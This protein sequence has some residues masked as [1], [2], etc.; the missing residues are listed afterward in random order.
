[1][2][3]SIKMALMLCLTL[4]LTSA[5]FSQ[6]Q[7]GSIT[8]LVTDNEGNTLPG[9]TL[10]VSSP[11]LMGTR[12]YVSSENGAFRFPA[13]PPGTYKLTAEMQAF[14]TV[15]RDDIV[16]R[17][18][19]VV[20]LDIIMQLT[21]IQEEVAVTAVA[22]VV[23]VQQ[24]KIAIS[25][26][27][28]QLRNLPVARDMLDVINSAP[29]ANYSEGG[30]WGGADRMTS[31]HGSSVR[32]NTYAFDG[33][34]MND[35]VNMNPVTNINFDVIEEVEMILGGQ[36]A[37]VG[38]T[39]GAYV[40]IVTRSG[41]N[42][43]TGGV[44]FYNINENYFQQ[45]WTNEQFQ[46]M[47]VAK[48][49]VDKNF[50]DLSFSLG[51]P[52]LRDKLWFFAN[53]RYLKNV[54][55]GTYLPWD[56]TYAIPGGW[57]HDP[58]PEW[59]HREMM[60]FGKLTTQ[61]TP[62]I[63]LM[64]MFNYTSTYRP[65]DA[66]PSSRTFFVATRKWDEN[67]SAATGTLTYILNQNT[68][69]DVKGSYVH[70]YFKQPFQD[71]TYDKGNVAIWNYGTNFS[72]GSY[73]S[74]EE[75]WTKN[76]YQITAGITR[77][78]ENWL[79]G[80]HEIKGGLEFTSDKNDWNWWRKDPMYW[81][82]YRGSPYYYG[83]TVASDVKTYGLPP[84]SVGIGYSLIGA[85]IVGPNEGDNPVADLG[86]HIS[87]FL[88]D[89]MTIA[90]RL[91]INA[92]IRYD[93][94][95]LDKPGM[96]MGQAGNEFVVWL[97][98]TVVKPYSKATYPSIFPNGIN[99][100][101]A[102]SAGDWKGVMKWSN[103]TPRLGLTFDLF[104][105]GK[106]A[107]KAFAGRYVDYLS[108]RFALAVSPFD[109]GWSWRIYWFDMNNNLNTD[110]QDY[111]WF[112]GYLYDIRKQDLNYARNMMDPNIK[113]PYTDE[114]TAGISHELTRNVF[115]GL[116]YHYKT[117]QNIWQRTYYNVDTQ[118][119][120]YHWDQ[121]AAKKYYT[122]FTS[123]VPGTGNY[124]D[125]EVTI[126][127]Q[128]VGGPAG[129]YRGANLPELSAKYQGL[130]FIFNKRMADGWQLSGSVVY[131]KAYGNLGGGYSETAG[132]TGSGITPN[133][134]TNRDAR[135][136]TDR[137]LAI[138]LMGTAQLPYGFLL[139]AYYRY[140]SGGP[141]GRST[142]IRPPAAWCAAN[143]AV[144]QDVSVFI[145]PMD[146]HRYPASNQLDLRLEKEFNVQ[147][148][149]RFGIFM[150]VLNLLGYTYVSV[151][152]NDI[153]RYSP[154]APNVREPANVIANSAYKVISGVSGL[155]S[156]RLCLRYSF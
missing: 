115:I 61:L 151:G 78:Q 11:A 116:N 125:R 90:H 66:T 142:T 123:I 64:G 109:P 38:F 86:T 19:M 118:E 29:G 23:D 53:G 55:R 26:D 153:S 131:S 156:L 144:Q 14:K 43:F 124:P 36:S 122:P 91:T 99:P 39:S 47:N 154:S 69:I 136:A 50:N 92:G 68:F 147:R 74:Y 49:S 54:K 35:P 103:I 145:E 107:L 30:G 12:T 83:K 85:W 119:Y 73:S 10:T 150:D 143:G 18:G 70:R 28:N 146:T 37:E 149:G 48:P 84:G 79:G 9:V 130:E 105:N 152:M 127:L 76:R 15:E 120:W 139:S 97:G 82:W 57:T 34:N 52:I 56:L 41:G 121:A 51:G 113:A 134:Y 4:G 40:N 106:T 112:P 24:S 126:Y 62:K 58:W 128:K 16:I 3:K 17:V 8:G 104:G 111:Y 5:V 31:I 63:R 102:A 21:T 138:K 6:V 65:I 77:F 71:G 46:A 110:K 80:N 2:K 108:L 129:F 88:Q 1:M 75:S 137:P 155:R 67:V 59:Y 93:H 42:K 20:T 132:W 98:E 27:S 96:K 89:S 100:W 33:I 101:L 148:V 141:W 140:F 22:P 87:A 81:Q 60:G 32:D 95:Q 45:L 117:K 135:Q 44:T 13:L 72:V 94:A 7:T 133:W 114:F 25:V